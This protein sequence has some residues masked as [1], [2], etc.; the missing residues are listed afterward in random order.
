MLINME[1]FVRLLEFKLWFH[2]GRIIVTGYATI[3]ME[4]NYYSP[5]F[6]GI[7][8]GELNWQN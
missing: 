1:I 8:G 2:M 4:S 5:I 7:D 6:I 3:S